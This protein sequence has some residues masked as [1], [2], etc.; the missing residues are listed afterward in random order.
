MKNEPEY[1]EFE[2]FWQDQNRKLLANNGFDS[3]RG[4]LNSDKL[5]IKRH[6]VGS[7]ELDFTV[8]ELPH[9]ECD[10]VA[11]INLN[12]NS[13]PLSM[14]QFALISVL[15]SV[16]PSSTKPA[17]ASYSMLLHLAYFLKSSGFSELTSCNIEAFH[18]SYLTESVTPDGVFSRLS[19]MSYN[20][21]YG[22]FSFINNRNAIKALG[23]SGVIGTSLTV[24]KI[25]NALNHACQVVL[26]CTLSEFKQGG[27]Y[28]FLS[29]ELG[30]YY[31]DF[32]RQVY[33]SD[34]FYT[35]ICHK[36]VTAAWEKYG[37]RNK[38][39][40][41]ISHILRV[42]P[43]VIKNTYIPH[44]GKLG[45]NYTSLNEVAHS[46]NESLFDLYT[47]H[48]DKVQSLSEKNLYSVA[49]KL[50]LA[51]RSDAVEI[52]RVLM[53]QKYYPF[54]ASKSPESVWKAYLSSLDKT[55]LDS[56]LIRNISIEQV[57]EAMS[58]VL[59]KDRLDHS[60]FSKSLSE[61]F[62]RLTIRNPNVTYHQMNLEF[63]RV[64]D[65]MTCLVVA[66]LG[67][68][69]SEFGFPLNAIH[70]E[71]N[72]DILDNSHVPFRFKLKWVVPKTNKVTKI[73]RE[74]TSQ[75][76]QVVAQLSDL[77][78]STEGEPCLYTSTGSH[79]NNAA[80][81]ESG[82]YIESRVKSNWEAFVWGYLPFEEINKLSELSKKD[83]SALDSHEQRLLNVL[84]KKYDLSSA[85]SKHLLDTSKEVRRDFPRLYCT[86]FGQKKQK[87]FKESLIEY[88]QSGNITNAV[89]K[90]IINKYLSEETRVW[91]RAPQINLDVKAMGDISNELLQGV[92]YPTPHAF[93][94]IW[95]EAVLNRYQG[96]VGA[97]IRH[98]FCH[99]DDSFFM[100]YLRNKEAKDLISVARSKVLNSIIDTLIVENKEIG[101]KYL[102]GFARF[103]GKASHVTKAVTSSEVRALKEQISKRVISLNSSYFATCIPREG[104][105]SRAKCSELGEMNPQNAKP[106]FCLGC[107]N[108]LI[109]EGNLKGVWMTLQPL[110]KESLNE[111]VMGFMVQH[112]LPT[113]RSGYKRIRELQN[114]RNVESVSKIL[115]F[116][117]KAMTTIETKLAE[118]EDLYV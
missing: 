118:E 70:T 85:R 116:I 58:H 2:L 107:T 26:G 48:F 46:F 51:S 72:L 95:A 10:K 86:G 60:G 43:T 106:S 113:L 77:F 22:A 83:I 37:L 102:G 11:L 17:Y 41:E 21:S 39:H 101:K 63:E 73:D 57:Y 59:E 42:F 87:A 67:Y 29:L 30:Q 65:A 25:D 14:K 27:S 50:G 68:R 49:E 56:Y 82:R 31:V 4:D 110:V 93:R 20:G 3:E 24:R 112:H 96:D 61:W 69:K 75:C 28:D 98:Q 64:S 92:R 99:L 6:G 84:S 117:E 33:E 7:V 40:N 97:V 94:H 62:H 71:P 19:P 35:S 78:Q 5:Y 32:C 23:V 18:L 79:K 76:Y 12:G 74:I 16:T 108:A 104:G 45:K 34:Y 80:S 91:L 8:F 54:T 53:L 109:T 55:H 13:Y 111:D 100:A 47:E 36:A 115:Q 89:H 1:S 105:E 44:E 81:N 103:V 38:K 15:S 52:I 90:E 9:L 66:W 114:D 88:H